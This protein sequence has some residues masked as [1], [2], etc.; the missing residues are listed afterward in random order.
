MTVFARDEACSCRLLANDNK[1]AAKVQTIIKNSKFA[2]FGVR[3][4]TYCSYILQ[5]ICIWKLS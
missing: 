1:L 5:N 3:T 2:E 4:F